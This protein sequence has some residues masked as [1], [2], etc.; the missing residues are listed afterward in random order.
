MTIGLIVWGTAVGLFVIGAAGLVLRR[1]LLAMLLG[2]ELMTNAVNVA[3]VYQARLGADAEGLA[4][5]FLLLA[6]AA[7]EAVIGLSLILA[8]ERSRRS[9]E[10]AGLRELRG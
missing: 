2:L 6:V 5:V 3:L 7:C 10:T 9:I 1:Q 4:T 8:L